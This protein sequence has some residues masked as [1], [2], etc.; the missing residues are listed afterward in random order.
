MPEI[1]ALIPARGGSKTVPRKNVLPLGGLPL[2]AHTILAAQSASLV[3]RVAVSTEDAEIAA[4]ARRFGAHVVP[5]PIELAGDEA[6]S[7]SALLHALDYLKD[8]EGYR[9]DILCFLQCTSPLTTA[10]DVDN[11][12][13]ALIDADADTAVAVTRFH[14]FVWKQDADGNAIGVNHDKAVRQRRQDRDNEYL[15][16]GAVYAMTAEGFRTAKHRFFG[17]T[18]VH[19]MPASRVLE[20]DDPED[21]ELAAERIDR[22]KK[23]TTR[24]PSRIE[25]IAFDFDGVFTD[26]CV[27]VDEHGTEAVRCSR[28]DGMGVEMLRDAGLP[29]IVLSKERNAVVAQRCEKLQLE[30]RQGQH[31]K[32]G[33]LEDWL[34]DQGI[35][36]TH[37]I[38]VGNDVNDLECMAA[39][40]VSVAPSDAHPAALAAAS[41]VLRAQGGRGAVRELADMILGAV[42]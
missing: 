21:F 29:M 6:S 30:Y 16:T 28:R 12:L 20:I 7:E 35:D 32:I 10:E 5:R 19:E 33:A 11:V 4:I 27:V 25:G 14:Y 17:R 34:G 13:A 24:L 40:G 39:A 42:T 18:V 38:Y 41:I 23:P 1:L 36:P 3:S 2:I 26:D 22:K 8:T 15:E 37:L 9:P 31:S